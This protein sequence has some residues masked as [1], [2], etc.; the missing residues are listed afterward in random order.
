M[1]MRI[2]P[3]KTLLPRGR[4]LDMDLLS[5]ARIRALILILR[6]AGSR[7]WRR[8]RNL[9]RNVGVAVAGHGSERRCEK[10]GA[11]DDENDGIGVAEIKVA[12]AHLLEQEEHADGDDN[13]GAHE[14]ADRASRATAFGI[15]AHRY[16]SLLRTDRTYFSG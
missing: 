12:A 10:N 13:R 6:R 4:P 14:R 5:L 9:L 11:D 1:M 3:L 15:V 2:R 8:R 7:G 16:S